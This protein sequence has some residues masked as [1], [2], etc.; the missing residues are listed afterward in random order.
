MTETMAL[1]NAAPSRFTREPEVSGQVRWG[2]LI[3]L[4]ALLS[5][6]LLVLPQA[7]FIM[8]SFHEDIGLGQVSDSTTIANYVAILTDPVYQRSIWLTIYM[9]AA[10]TTIGLA[11]GF[12][13]AY[14]LAR[15]G[16]WT[17]RLAL[18]LALTTSLITIVIKLLG[19]NLLLGSSGPINQFLICIGL[20]AAPIAFTDSQLGVLIGLVQYTLPVLILMLFSVAQTIPATLEEAASIHGATRPHIFFRIILP[21]A[22]PGLVSGGLIAFNMSMGAFTSAVLLGG[23][24]VRT[25]PV[26]IQEKMMQSTEYGMGAALST[27]LLVLVFF[28]NVAVATGATR[29]SQ[30][31]KYQ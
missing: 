19:L 20:I 8:M 27:V 6:A 3:V 1:P 25:M 12:P 14:A 24:R 28:M 18:S 23:G 15:L 13:T 30:P 17:A 11:I 16:G 2:A 4:P 26:L 9:S 10:A 22:K 21:L 31:R 7:S 5:F 29:R